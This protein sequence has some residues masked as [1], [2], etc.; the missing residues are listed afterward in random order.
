MSDQSHAYFGVF[1]VGG[2][3]FLSWIPEHQRLHC[4]WN[5]GREDDKTNM[6]D[7]DRLIL[8]GAQ[9]CFATS[10][11]VEICVCGTLGA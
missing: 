5:I 7:F 6:H 3:L 9:S 4:T 1:V 8:H 10:V 11:Y 2:F